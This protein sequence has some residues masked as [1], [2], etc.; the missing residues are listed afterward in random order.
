MSLWLG[1]LYYRY[2]RMVSRWIHYGRQG[3]QQP[4]AGGLK[5][6]RY[7]NAY[8]PFFFY[9][10]LSLSL[11]VADFAVFLS[12]KKIDNQSDQQPDAEAFPAFEW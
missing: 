5:K 11:R 3:H 1:S 4:I 10:S 7:R 12:V 8:R 9:F 6:G 2:N